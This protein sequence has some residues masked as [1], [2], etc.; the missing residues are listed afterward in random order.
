M[1][2]INAKKLIKENNWPLNYADPED[3]EH[4]NYFRKMCY[5]G[6]M[7][8]TFNLIAN[9]L[10]IITR[11]M[12]LKSHIFGTIL[13]EVTKGIQ[14]LQ[15]DDNRN[16]ND[17]QQQSGYGGHSNQQAGYLEQSS[18]YTGEGRNYPG[19]QGSYPNSSGRREVGWVNLQGDYPGQ[20]G[21]YLG[22]QGGYPS[23]QGRYPGQQGSYPGQQGG[24]P[25]GYPGEQGGYPNQQGGYTNQRTS[26]PQQP[27]YP[28]QS[29]N[30]TYQGLGLGQ[31]SRSKLSSISSC[32]YFS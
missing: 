4:Q 9:R 8:G 15:P 17:R 10:P 2:R 5:R 28:H 31:M 32:S 18:G 19:Q 20:Q 30:N 13:N 23:Q 29:I 21:S 24:Y 1:S 3:S 16:S 27:Q 11:I 25:G 7:D 6:H 12:P 14:N 26:Y 22:Q